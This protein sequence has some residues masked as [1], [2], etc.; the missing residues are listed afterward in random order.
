MNVEVEVEE[1]VGFAPIPLVCHKGPHSPHGMQLH[2]MVTSDDLEHRVVVAG[3][4][5]SERHVE[6]GYIVDPGAEDDPA[7]LDVEGVV[8]QVEAAL[9]LEEK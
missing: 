8:V 5:V 4:A 6:A 7:L 9:G 1:G 2:Q 3:L